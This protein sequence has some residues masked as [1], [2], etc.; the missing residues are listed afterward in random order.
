M[1]PFTSQGQTVSFIEREGAGD[2]PPSDADQ[3]EGTSPG[4]GRQNQ[5]ETQPS[6]LAEG[7]IPEQ[8]P[9]SPILLQ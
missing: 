1:G 4:K 3:R 6:A 7:T 9:I 5:P 2:E 8:S